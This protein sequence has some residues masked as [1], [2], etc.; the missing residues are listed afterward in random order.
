MTREATITTFGEAAALL[1]VS[2]NTI[3]D[4]VKAHGIAWSRVPHGNAKGLDKRAMRQLRKILN[5]KPPED[6]TPAGR[7]E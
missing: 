4:L 3:G 2:P 1:E 7:P 6:L 5:R